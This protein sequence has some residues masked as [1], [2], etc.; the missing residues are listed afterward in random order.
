[1]GSDEGLY[2]QHPLY[3]LFPRAAG[4]KT[5]QSLEDSFKDPFLRPSH[6]LAVGF[7]YIFQ[8]IATVSQ[9]LKVEH[10]F[11]ERRES[12]QKSGTVGINQHQLVAVG[13]RSIQE[14]VQVQVAEEHPFLV[15]QSQMRCYGSRQ[16]SVIVLGLDQSGISSGIAAMGRNKVTCLKQA[17]RS[18][19]EIGNP[20][21]C[22]KASQTQFV[23]I[24]I[25]PFGLCLTKESI[26]DALEEMS[27]LKS[28]ITKAADSIAAT[29]IAA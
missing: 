6:G 21:R 15:Q 27:F 20:A 5:V 24:Q 8:Q 22:V 28:F 25:S 7:Q 13:L 29:N 4:F 10:A 1:M 19:L 3:L 18:L 23:C 9:R 26:G 11:L 16:F 17:S 14:I 12:G 2:P